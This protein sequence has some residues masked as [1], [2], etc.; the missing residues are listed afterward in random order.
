MESKK[1][2]QAGT[3]KLSAGFFQP[4]AL[5]VV[6]LVFVLLLLSLATMYFR[7]LDKTLIAYL[8]DIE[9]YFSSE[10]MTDGSYL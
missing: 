3:R 5:G 1:R 8:I 6:G 2:Y 4:L 10:S 9:I 7:T